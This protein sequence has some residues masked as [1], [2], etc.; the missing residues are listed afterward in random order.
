MGIH[1]TASRFQDFG[2]E[3]AFPRLAIS[4]GFFAYLEWEDT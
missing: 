1:Y 3:L 2:A 4:G